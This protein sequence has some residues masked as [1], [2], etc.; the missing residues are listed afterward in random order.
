MPLLLLVSVGHGIRQ[1]LAAV[2]DL[3]RAQLRRNRTHL[4]GVVVFLGQLTLADRTLKQAF[5][6]ID[7]CAA[8]K[9]KQAPAASAWLAASAAR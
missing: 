3:V 7:N 1:R 5:E 8:L 2:D 6:R 9:S 4:V